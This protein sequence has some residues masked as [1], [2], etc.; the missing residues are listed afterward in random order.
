MNKN[1]SSGLIRALGLGALIIYGVGDILGAGIYAL[2]GKIAGHAGSLTWLSFAIA[3]GI[4]SLTALSYSELGSRFPKSGGVSI[5]IHEAFGTQ[6]FS[7]LTGLLLF[8]ATVLS[9][10]TLSHAFAGYLRA[11]GFNIPRSLDVFGF[12]LI[13][14][15]IN[16]RGI[17]QSSTAN[18]ISTSVEVSGLVLV[19]G[20]GFWYLTTHHSNFI[21]TPAET[22]EIGDVLQGT[23]LAFF[24]FTGFEDMA[25]IAEEVKE[26]QKNLPRAILSSLG[27]AGILYLGVSWIATTIIPGSELS[28]SEAP[29]LDVVSKSAPALPKSLFSI[30]A[31]FAVSNS[32][33]LNYI[34]ASRLLY[35]MSKE[36]LLPKSLQRVHAKF[37]TPYSAIFLIFPIVL[38]LVLMS[39][40]GDLA[41]STSAIVLIVFSLSNLA[42]IKIK[43]NTKKEKISTKIFRIPLL[44]PC[45][46]IGLNLAAISFLP[47][48]N[49]IPAAVLIVI[50]GFITWGIMKSLLSKN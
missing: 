14:L 5:Y 7:I 26:P 16:L 11:L 20:C 25:N 45:L 18:I 15:L 12:L 1:S 9:M 32:A 24:A 49:I 22:P 38:C 13:L 4:I 47:L 36:N 33:L 21:T 48:H 17:K 39:N 43:L 50:C 23:A 34:T 8:C 41:S 3:M 27:I 30:I 6:W 35:G 46:A 40:L 10:S 28:S 29:L 42:L 19:L 37:H 31:I 44:V 2:V